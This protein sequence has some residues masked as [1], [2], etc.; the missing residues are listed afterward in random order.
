MLCCVELCCRVLCCVKLCCRV[1]CCFEL[2]YVLWCGAVHLHCVTT[3]P[4]SFW[5]DRVQSQFF[6]FF[7]YST[8]NSIHFF[9]T[10][11]Y[12]V[13]EDVQ[14]QYEVVGGA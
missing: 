11:F 14:A 2:C 9:I 5:Y 8:M 6:F 4:F 13:A 1:F 7:F 3:L 12:A 10:H